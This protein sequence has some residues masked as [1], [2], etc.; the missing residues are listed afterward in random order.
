MVNSVAMIAGHAHSPSTAITNDVAK[1]KH[2][3]YIKF[4]SDPRPSSRHMP[5]HKETLC[6]QYR[7]KRLLVQQL[8]LASS[9]LVVCT[10]R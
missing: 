3:Y 10:Q 7:F 2:S 4:V 8:E 5:K 6:Q 9:P 1:H